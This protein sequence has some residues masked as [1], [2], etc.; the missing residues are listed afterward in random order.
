MRNKAK[1]RVLPTLNIHRNSSDVSMP[2]KPIEPPG[3]NLRRVVVV[4]KR[5]RQAGVSEET[6]IMTHDMCSR[7]SESKKG[8]MH[9]PARMRM[10]SSPAYD[11]I[12]R[13]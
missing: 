11:N 10:E 12:R 8:K 6:T 4:P 3:V 1:R 9:I 13:V 5:A 2:I 7:N